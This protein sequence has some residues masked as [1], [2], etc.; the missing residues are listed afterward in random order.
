M[1][2]THAPIMEAVGNGA[3]Y[4]N[5]GGWA[6]DDLDEH[7]GDAHAD[8]DDQRDSTVAQDAP[9]PA[10]TV[11]GS[12]PHLQ[13][14]ERAQAKRAPCTHLVIRHV[15]GQPRAELRRWDS[16]TR[17]AAVLHWSGQADLESTSHEPAAQ[18]DSGVRA[19]PDVPEE[20]V[21]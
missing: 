15:D 11:N 5:L 19:L 21:A 20:Q 2:H 18:A 4:V 6:V 10:Q 8:Q 7:H 16:R 12:A 17:A 1:G 9:A 14:R 13:A 3:T